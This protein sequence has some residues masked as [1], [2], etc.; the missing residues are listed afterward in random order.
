MSRMACEGCTCEDGW[1]GKEQVVASGFG[2]PGFQVVPVKAPLTPEV[3][4]TSRTATNDSFSTTSCDIAKAVASTDASAAASEAPTASVKQ[5]SS[6]SESTM[7]VNGSPLQ[8]LQESHAETGSAPSQ[9]DATFGGSAASTARAMVQVSSHTSRCEY[10]VATFVLQPPSQDL[11]LVSGK[12]AQPA[13]S[14]CRTC[15]ISCCCGCLSMFGYG[16]CCVCIACSSFCSK[17]DKVDAPDQCK[18]K[19]SRTGH[20]VNTMSS[21]S[22][23]ATQDP[24]A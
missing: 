18:G 9:S 15:C 14:P 2:F 3:T 5:S 4:S 21:I 10:S 24:L 19:G 23:D 11:M 7:P 17:N 22:E 1:A 20:G 16:A 13:R 12:A 8:Q 6:V